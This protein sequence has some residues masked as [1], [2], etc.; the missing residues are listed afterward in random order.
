MMKQGNLVVYGLWMWWVSPENRK[1][2]ALCR[3][4]SVLGDMSLVSRSLG[5]GLGSEPGLRPETRS[6]ANSGEQTRG[7]DRGEDTHIP[8]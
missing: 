6:G 4:L 2:T 3:V 7:G 1:Q 5:R 8:V